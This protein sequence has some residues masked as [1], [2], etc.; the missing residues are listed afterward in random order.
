M[1]STVGPIAAQRAR[2]ARLT[3]EVAQLAAAHARSGADRDRR[4]A[5]PLPVVLLPA[6]TRSLVPLPAAS[7]DAFLARL[8][9]ALARTMALPLPLP[10]AMEPTA[11]DEAR[12]RADAGEAAS[13][14]A[15]LSLGMVG[16]SCGTCGGACC[17][18]GGTHAFLKED[19]LLRI[20]AQRAG[21][22]EAADTPAAIRALYAAALPAEHYH[23]SCVFHARAGCTLPRG[24]RSNLCNRYQCGGLT[25]LSRA[26]TTSGARAVYVGAADATRV[27]RVALVTE[28]GVVAV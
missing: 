20:R 22:A 10:D 11:T 7:R 16:G 1:S 5:W 24:L 12:A 6:N 28:E 23:D 14:D 8:D 25:Q 18:A 4:D 2:N 13:W 9:L 17:T 15:S 3:A 26:M 27:Q 21:G 19:S